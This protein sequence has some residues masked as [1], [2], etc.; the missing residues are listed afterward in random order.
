MTDKQETDF[1]NAEQRSAVNCCKANGHNWS[2]SSRCQC[3]GWP[4][5][6]I[7]ANRVAYISELEEKRDRYQD[8]N[9]KLREACK[10]SYSCG[11]QDYHE[12]NAFAPEVFD[13]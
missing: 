6:H 11:W 7:E 4:A 10:V 3:C 13:K 2:E 12:G 1:L 9:E 5:R 8:E